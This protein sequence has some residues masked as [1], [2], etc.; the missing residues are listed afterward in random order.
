M[1]IVIAAFKEN[2]LLERDL[3][4]NLIATDYRGKIYATGYMLLYSVKDLKLSTHDV[5]PEYFCFTKYSLKN[6]RVLN[7]Y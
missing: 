4:I 2:V 7:I 5:P 3:R 6:Y 1:V